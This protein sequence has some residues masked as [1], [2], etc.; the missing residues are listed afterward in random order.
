[1]RR[2]IVAVFVVG[3][4]EQMGFKQMNLGEKPEL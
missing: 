2:H 4:L 1:L 3:T